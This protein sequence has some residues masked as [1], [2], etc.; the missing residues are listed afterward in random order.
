MDNFPNYA[1]SDKWL[2]LFARKIYSQNTSLILFIGENQ[3]FDSLV[4]ISPSFG[5]KIKSR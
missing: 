2:E 5:L 1:I 4:K 3:N